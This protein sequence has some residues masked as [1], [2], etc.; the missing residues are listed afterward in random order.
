[1]SKDLLAL[2]PPWDTLWKKFV[3]TF[4]C[5]PAVTVDKLD[6]SQPKLYTIPIV[7]D[8]EKKGTALATLIR[9][10]FPMGNI[11]VV[12]AVKNSKGQAW[13]PI[14][15]HDADETV[16]VFKTAF[17][18]NTLFVNAA[19]RG[20][21]NDVFIIMTKSIVQFFNDDM[22]DYYY[23]FNGVTAQVLSELIWQQ[24]ANN[25]ITCLTSTAA[26]K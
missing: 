22:S 12:T 1:M 25:T 8:D 7:V 19:K 23:N 10:K 17:K 20:P 2:S 9:S 5:D 6:T 4:G 11:T 16:A 21:F 14:I 18:G 24:Y 26:D 13:A 3:N 15:I